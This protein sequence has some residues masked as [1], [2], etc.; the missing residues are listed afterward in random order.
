MDVLQ[1]NV[2]YPHFF[3]IIRCFFSQL[4]ILICISLLDS[5]TEFKNLNAIMLLFAFFMY[6]WTAPTPLS[7]KRV[8]VNFNSLKVYFLTQKSNS[9]MK[10]FCRMDKE[11][12]NKLKKLLLNSLIENSIIFKTYFFF[13]GKIIK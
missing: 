11:V 6:L 5:V 12:K 1:W 13:T 2:S 10:M 8:F 4:R 7:L 3:F 9:R